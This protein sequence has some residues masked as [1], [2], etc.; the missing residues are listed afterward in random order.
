MLLF[1]LWAQGLDALAY[2]E[3]MDYEAVQ[4]TN[5]EFN[6]SIVRI[7]V[8]RSHRQTVQCVLQP[9]P[10]GCMFACCNT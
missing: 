4:S 3:H 8:F 6:N 7:N 10:H 9:Q 1:S 2:S 5:P